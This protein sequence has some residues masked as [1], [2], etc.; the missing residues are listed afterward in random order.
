MRV[1]SGAMA[2]HL[3]VAGQVENLSFERDRGQVAVK[4]TLTVGGDEDQGSLGGVHI[5]DFAYRLR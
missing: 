2:Y 1:N 4:G 3:P 5:T